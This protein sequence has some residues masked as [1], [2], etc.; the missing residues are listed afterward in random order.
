MK[1]LLLKYEYPHM[2]WI[3]MLDPHIW[4]TQVYLVMISTDKQISDM[5]YMCPTL[6]DT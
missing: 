5:T 4:Q 2:C 3:D 6:L 1:Y